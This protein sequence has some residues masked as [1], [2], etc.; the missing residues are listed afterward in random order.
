MVRG[1]RDHYASRG[2]KRFLL[3]TRDAHALYAREGFA[4]VE[5][6]RWMECDLRTVS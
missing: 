2:L 3:V 5:A 6:G 1:L 4:A